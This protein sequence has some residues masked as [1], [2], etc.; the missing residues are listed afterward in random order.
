[1][2]QLVDRSLFITLLSSFWSGLFSTEVSLRFVV[3]RSAA[4]FFYNPF[5]VVYPHWC[6][7][8][9][10]VQ[11]ITQQRPSPRSC[12][13][14]WRVLSVRHGDLQRLRQVMASR[15]SLSTRTPTASLLLKLYGIILEMYAP[16][17]VPQKGDMQE[18]IRTLFK[19]PTIIFN[20]ESFSSLVVALK[21]LHEL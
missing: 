6:C 16:E 21:N 5:L 15:H 1:M 10:A 14:I 12:S 13:T 9:A 4:N 18:M 20:V 7:A 8:M 3:V 11:E 17:R 2:S 19:Y